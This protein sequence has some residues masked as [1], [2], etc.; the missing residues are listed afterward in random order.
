MRAPATTASCASDPS[1]GGDPHLFFG[2]KGSVLALAF[3]PDGRWL[4]SAGDDR[5]IR[6]WPVPDV[7]KTP[8][9]KRPREEFLAMLRTWTN[10]RVVPDSNS[11][12]GWRMDADPFPGW[13]KL[14]TW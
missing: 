1:P 5:T 14:P 8:P 13:E 2:H 12:T 4:A 11:P 9:H 7:T 6:P 10:L 3:S